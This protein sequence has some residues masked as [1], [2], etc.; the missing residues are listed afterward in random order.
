M[1]IQISSSFTTFLNILDQFVGMFDNMY[2]LIH[3]I[4][5]NENRSEK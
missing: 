1:A 5:E 2:S 3:K 4:K